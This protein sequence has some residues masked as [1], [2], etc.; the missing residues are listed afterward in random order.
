M[1]Y[2]HPWQ[3]WSWEGKVWRLQLEEVQ[4]ER[5]LWSIPEARSH[6]MPLPNDKIVLS[7]WTKY[8]HHLKSF[9]EFD[10]TLVFLWNASWMNSV[11]H[12]CC[13]CG[14]KHF[15]EDDKKKTSFLLWTLQGDFFLDSPSSRVRVLACML[16]RVRME[17]GAQP[18]VPRRH[19][20]HFWGRISPWLWAHRKG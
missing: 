13:H 16:M 3:I 11:L 8:Q 14:K 19:P 9:P 7:C 15:S 2:L 4:I 1:I 6:G 17:A 5:H 20:P 12:P 18:L 10:V